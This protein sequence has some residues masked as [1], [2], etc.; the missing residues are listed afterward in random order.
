MILSKKSFGLSS[1]ILAT[2]WMFLAVIVFYSINRFAFS[3]TF[4]YY[5]EIL[6]PYYS[7]FWS[8]FAH[9]DGIHYSIIALAGRYPDAGQVAFFPLFPFLIHFLINIGIDRLI[10]GL[11]VSNLS[12]LISLIIFQYVYPKSSWKLP[13]LLLTFPTSFFFAS[14]YTESL[15]LMLFALMLLFIKKQQYLL[16]AMSV[17]LATATRFVGIGMI[18]YLLFSVWGKIKFRQII[19]LSFV[20]IT[21]ILGYIYYLWQ[22]TADP[23]AFIHAQPIFGMGR[24]GGKIILLPQ[25]IY[26]YFKMLIYSDPN[27]LLYWR[28]VAELS[29]FLLVAYLLYKFWHKLSTSELVYTLT[30][31]LIPTLSGSLSSYPRYVLIAIP[32]FSILSKELSNKWIVII[33]GVQACLLVVSL[34]FF[35]RGLFVA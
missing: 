1:I 23:L 2:W 14:F 17:A 10:A 34:S 32:L 5:S 15:Y 28:A 6:A 19:Q 21:G 33:S 35:A 31:L 24:S 30:V 29:L 4:P 16:A 9:F 22:T 13:I 25:V 12:L 27:T 3:P 8:T 26:R 18:L 20:S 11:L 7:R